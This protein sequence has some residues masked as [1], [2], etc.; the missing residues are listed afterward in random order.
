MFEKDIIDSYINAYTRL[1]P[2]LNKNSFT[3]CKTVD[4]F[5]EELN[6]TDINVKPLS[7]K[8]ISLG[9]KK[10][11]PKETKSFKQIIRAGGKENNC[12]WQKKVKKRRILVVFLSLF[13]S[14]ILFYISASSFISNL[15]SNFIKYLFCVIYF[16]L[17]YSASSSLFKMIVGNIISKKDNSF[18][19]LKDDTQYKE[20]TK[21]AILYPVYNEDPARVVAS[22][23]ATWKGLLEIQDIDKHYDF[24][25]LSDTRSIESRILEETAII[26]AKKEFKNIR[27]YYRWRSIN[28]N[29]KLGNIMDF[30]RRYSSL[31]KYMVVMDADSLMSGK[32]IHKIVSIA[33]SNDQIGIIQTNPKPIL[34]T[35]IFGRMLQFSCWFY[36]IP[37]FKAIRHYYLGDAFYIGH[38]ALIR[39]DAFREH[40]VLPAL[41]G[42]P[43]WGGK[44]LSHDLV[45]AG[46][47]A[48][49]GLEVWFLPEIEESYE[50]IPANIIAFLIRERRWMQGNLQNLRVVFGFGLKN[51]HRD[52]LIAGFMSYFSSILW[53]VFTFIVAITGVSFNTNYQDGVNHINIKLDTV[54]MLYYALILLFAPRLIGMIFVI[55]T[56]EYKNFGGYI[57]VLL[58]CLFDTIFSICFAPIVMVFVMK[59]FI[60]WIKSKPIKWGNQDR[61]DDILPWRTCFAEFSLPMISGIV[62]LLWIRM[63]ELSQLWYY[64]DYYNFFIPELSLNNRYL[65]FLPIIIALICSP[66]TARLSSATIRSKKFSKIFLIPEEI[67]QSS[68]ITNMEI[69][70]DKIQKKLPNFKNEREAI[71]FAYTDPEFFIY[72]YN[73]TFN[74]KVKQLPLLNNQDLGHYEILKNVFNH[75]KLFLYY[76]L[77][78]S[79]KNLNMGS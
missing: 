36:G 48:K 27:L 28:T 26:L 73:F 71:D 34:R 69:Y 18:K 56:K 50:E 47:M 15:D 67:K 76:H 8:R 41:D 16:I 32:A 55:L 64:N 17:T 39:V 77:N 45:E 21:I 70:L 9:S 57:W 68:I 35:T 19:K 2:S 74:R 1:A 25:I 42:I 31:Y 49:S 37:F 46:L 62:L 22:I 53:F 40:C 7:T 75:R 3:S 44:P 72:H 51:A 66:L 10:I 78:I 30:L 24:Y 59:F 4:E 58:S 65:W 14:T 38:N 33:E 11:N 6:K 60:M 54:I 13:F 79:K 43:P 63:S 20:N 29:A 5:L 12:E 61:G 23:M 52:L